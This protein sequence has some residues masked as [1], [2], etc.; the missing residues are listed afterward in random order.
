MLGPIAAT[1]N[2]KFRYMIIPGNKAVTGADGSLKIA[3]P[4]ALKG[5]DYETVTKMFNI[6]K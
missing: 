5:M 1:D 4:A 6:P 2:V 3:T